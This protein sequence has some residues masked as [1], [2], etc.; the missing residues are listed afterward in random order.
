MSLRK[1]VQPFLRGTK[2]STHGGGVGAG[3][4]SL[5]C[6][7]QKILVTWFCRSPFHLLP[8]QSL[9]CSALQG[10]L[11]GGMNNR[12]PTGIY[13]FSDATLCAF[14]EPGSEDGSPKRVPVRDACHAELN[15]PPV[16]LSL[17]CG[18]HCSSTAPC[19]AVPV[20]LVLLPC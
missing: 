7:A 4:A 17:S 12:K 14:A 20:L 2:Q 5:H 19:H 9:N 15:L 13:G 6:V 16:L 1:Q 3:K 8:L 10:A 11:A 18:G